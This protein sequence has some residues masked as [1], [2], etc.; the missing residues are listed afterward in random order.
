MAMSVFTP[1]AHATTPKPL[2]YQDSD[3]PGTNTLTEFA[4]DP[5]TGGR[6]PSVQLTQ[7][8]RTYSGQGFMLRIHEDL[9]NQSDRL[10]IDLVVFNLR[11]PFGRA[12]QFRGKIQTGG[13]AGRL[14]GSGV[15]ELA[16]TGID[17]DNWTISETPPPF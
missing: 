13:I 6:K 8:G 5:A 14:L 12:F 9:P 15:Y 7:N 11:D 4:P 17:L 2:R 16:G 10:F 1:R 3:G